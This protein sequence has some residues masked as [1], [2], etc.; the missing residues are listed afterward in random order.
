MVNINIAHAS[1]LFGDNE[2]NELRIKISV[3]R[4]NSYLLTEFRAK[5]Y[6]TISQIDKF[7]SATIIMRKLVM[8]YSEWLTDYLQCLGKKMY[9][10]IVLNA[11]KGGMDRELLG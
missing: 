1:A 4:T 10:H 7:E 2:Y 9:S 11:V 3:F 6:R 5:A 8:E